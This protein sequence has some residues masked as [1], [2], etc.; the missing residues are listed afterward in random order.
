MNICVLGAGYVG[1]VTSTTL[2]YLGNQVV[3]VESNHKRLEVLQ[4]GKIPFFEPNLEE[5]AKLV[6]NQDLLSFTDD[7]NQA[8]KQADVVFIAVGTPQLSDGQPDLSQVLAAAKSIGLALDEA[9]H[10]VI[11]NKSTVPVGSGNWVE[12][13]IKQSMLQGQLTPARSNKVAPVNFSV[14][15]NPEFLKEGSAVF[16]SFFP[17]RIV[18]G[19]SDSISASII[20]EMYAPIIN[21]SFEPPA[22]ISR[23]NNFTDVPFVEVDIA[24]AELIKYASNAFLAMKISF[25]N[26]MSNIAE[27]VGANINK[28]MSAIGLDSRIGQAFLSA[29]VGWG[30]SCFGKDINALVNIAQEY[31]IN[32]N[33]LPAT[34]N[35][36]EN[37]RLVV[38]R[39]L[40]EELK[41]LKGRTIGIMGLSF[42]PN[43]DDLR[44]APSLTI[45]AQLLK[46]GASIKAYDPVSNS[47]F[48]ECKPELDIVYCDTM[49]TLAKDCDA[50][51]LVTEWDEFTNLNWS[52]IR[53]LIRNPLVIDGRNCLNRE[54]LVELGFIYKGVGV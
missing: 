28:V 46:M 21:Q 48:K 5:L 26:E 18:V 49:E 11:I 44:D 38:I 31:N 32:L 22:N 42:K 4:Q 15:S 16:D 36:N 54:Y 51:V 24:S 9:C 3:N 40:Q 25:A 50:L 39:K 10:R 14:V 13:L 43:T 30:G 53:N 34:I 1:L 52:K 20:R 7:V 29:G 35:V 47:S 2:A 6:I 17:D 19:V 23:P 41:I 12:M 37:Q 27:K 45:I 8:I 33:L